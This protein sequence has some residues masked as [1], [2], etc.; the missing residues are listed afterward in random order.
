[1]IKKKSNLLVCCTRPMVA[2]DVDYNSLVSKEQSN[3]QVSGDDLAWSRAA[4]ARVGDHHD[5]KATIKK[6]SSRLSK[7]FSSL[8]KVFTR[9]DSGTRKPRKKVSKIIKAVFI[10][11]CSLVRKDGK[12][13]GKKSPSSTGQMPNLNGKLEEGDSRSTSDISSSIFTRSSAFSSSSRSLGSRSMISSKCSNSKIFLERNTFVVQRE[14]DL[15]ED[16]CEPKAANFGSDIGLKLLLLS[17]VFLVLWGKACAILC[18]STWLLFG[19]TGRSTNLKLG[20]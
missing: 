9:E 10:F 17:L 18:T 14:T 13:S 8:P 7:S 12:N 15:E 2:M 11:H 4:S 3:M 20:S 5:D 16:D 1:M 19:P 6:V